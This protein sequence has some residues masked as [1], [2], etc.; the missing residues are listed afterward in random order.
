[1]STEMIKCKLC[2]RDFKVITHTHLKKEHN[3]DSLEE[4]EIITKDCVV[5][6][7]TS[8][9]DEVDVSE[10]PTVDDDATDGSLMGSLLKS[11]SK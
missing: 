1:M 11:W 10:F 8:I 2:E 3:I 6:Q 7:P 4:Y 9:L 5:E